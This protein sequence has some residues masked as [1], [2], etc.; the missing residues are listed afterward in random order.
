[1]KKCK[2]CGQ[3]KPYDQF[4]KMAEMR[5]GHRNDCKAC[6]LAA[7]ASRY[8]ADPE[9]GKARVR[10]WQQQ[11][12]ERVTQYRK[13]YNATQ[14]RRTQNRAGHRGRTSHFTSITIMRRVQYAGCCASPTTTSSATREMMLRVSM[15]RRVTCTGTT[16]LC[17]RRRSLSGHA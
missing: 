17:G 16:R 9:R 3:I 14:D 13:R 12:P 2:V 6:N 1:M 8:R 4:Y 11:N 7:K 10:Q 5:D 15:R